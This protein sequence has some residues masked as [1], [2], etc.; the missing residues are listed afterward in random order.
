MGTS[1][2]QLS[3]RP[4]ALENCKHLPL[5]ATPAVSNGDIS[6]RT[7]VILSFHQATVTQIQGPLTA[8]SVGG[9]GQEEGGGYRQR[10]VSRS[11]ELTSCCRESP[12]NSVIV[13]ASIHQ[14]P[15]RG[16]TSL[17]IQ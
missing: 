2:R 16:N 10:D 4:L 13:F 6:W 3:C 15:P 11:V 5:K 7:V 1:P 12:V 8:V 14:T 17:P 9:G